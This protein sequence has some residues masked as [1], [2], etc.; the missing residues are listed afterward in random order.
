MYFNNN[1]YFTYWFSLVWWLSHATSKV[2]FPH[3]FF[4]DLPF[5][6]YKCPFK[7]HI[8]I[9]YLTRDMF[10]QN[11]LESP[12]CTTLKMDTAF[13]RLLQ[14]SN[15]HC[16][17]IFNCRQSDGSMNKVNFRGRGPPIM[18][19]ILPIMLCCTTQ[20][21]CLLCSNY[22]HWD[23]AISWY[24]FHKISCIAWKLYISDIWSADY[25]S[26]LDKYN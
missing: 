7:L 1:Y 19:K 2:P 3:F 13:R 10:R 24:L 21:L 15:S 17:M 20:K 6:V 5:L 18:L 26:L 9:T 14:G 22:A 25:K 12:N 16:T 8:A 23:W 4:F 11:L